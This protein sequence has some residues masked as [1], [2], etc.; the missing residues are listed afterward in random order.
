L[1][2]LLPQQREVRFFETAMKERN[3]EQSC[4]VIL[5]RHEMKR[6]KKNKIQN[7]VRKRLQNSMILV[8]HAIF[9]AKNSEF[10][11]LKIKIEYSTCRSFFFSQAANAKHVIFSVFE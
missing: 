9:Q 2:Q 10:G 1:L 5:N 4:I 8:H 11:I 7:H 3:D 6:R